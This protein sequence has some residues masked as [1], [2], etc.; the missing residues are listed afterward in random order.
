MIHI[1]DQELIQ[2]TPDLLEERYIDLK[3]DVAEYDIKVWRN[4]HTAIVDLL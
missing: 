1:N 2:T 4:T 3:I